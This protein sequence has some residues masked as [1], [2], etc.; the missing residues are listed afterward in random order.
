ME[1]GKGGHPVRS[2]KVLSGHAFVIK[3]LTVPVRVRNLCTS[4]CQFE[5]S[6]SVQ[7][8]LDMEKVI[9]KWTPLDQPKT[10]LRIRFRNQTTDG[11]RPDAKPI[12]GFILA[13]KGLIR[14]QVDLRLHTGLRIRFD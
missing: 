11:S 2:Q 1:V 7:A 13:L 6:T 12:Y 3:K 8:N 14:A 10:A 5:H 9:Q 4:G